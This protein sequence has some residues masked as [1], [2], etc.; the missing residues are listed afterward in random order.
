MAQ[1][2]IDVLAH[3]HVRPHRV[4]LEHHADIAQA[5][6]H[7]HAALRR[8]DLVAADRDHAGGRLL[9]ARDAA[10]RRGLAAAGRPEQHDDLARRDAEADVVDRR[11]ADQELLAQMRDDQFGGHYLVSVITNAA[12]PRESGDPVLWLW[13]L[14]CPGM[15]GEGSL[16]VAVDLVPLLDPVFLQLHELVVFRNPHLH[17]FADR[18]LPDRAAP[19][20]AR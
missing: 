13:M 4:G 5:R 20:S 3:R 7:M 17:D 10:Q 14:A 8:R 6:R 12:R 19:S 16:P 9:Q 1:R 11:A 2:I 15:S 18:N